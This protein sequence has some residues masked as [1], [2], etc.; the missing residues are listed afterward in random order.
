[1]SENPLLPHRKLRD[2]HAL[3]LHCRD[4]EK[5]QVRSAAR[6]AFLA[7]TA[8]HLV[9][10]DLLSAEPADQ[11][12]P[13]LAPDA[14]KDSYNSVL[15]TAP[16]VTSRLALCAAAARGLQAA[17]TKTE[18]AGV[19]LATVRAGTNETGW[20]TALEW[21]QQAQLPLILACSDATNGKAARVRRGEP[22]FDWA[23]VSR[24]AK[25]TKLAVLSV[26]GEDAVAVYRVMQESALRARLGGGPAVI[27]GVVSPVV[28]GQRLP[29]SRQPIVRLENYLA[30]RNIKL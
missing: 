12:T 9:P 14:K 25:R 15:A 30:Q 3:M 22:A 21:A 19:V 5:K 2:L 10:G 1:L 13:H 24:F 16:V 7:A 20:Q 4:L 28:A 8:M 11:T 18:D 17:T 23:S 27:W 6:E 26:D 29:R